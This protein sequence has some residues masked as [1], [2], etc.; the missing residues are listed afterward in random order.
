M[1]MN[2]FMMQ[3]HVY[4]IMNFK[5]KMCLLKINSVTQHPHAKYCLA[6]N[7]ANAVDSTIVLYCRS[8]NI[9]INICVIYI[10]MYVCIYICSSLFAITSH[11]FAPLLPPEQ[12]VH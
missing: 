10:Y 4:F 1:L 6:F 7:K 5:T 11:V 9:F 12:H 3:Q 8:L 2:L